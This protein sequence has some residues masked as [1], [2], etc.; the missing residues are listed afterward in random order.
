MTCIMDN[1][2]KIHVMNE[3]NKKKQKN[4]IE[5]YIS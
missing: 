3:N 1:T 5:N 2:E 4:E